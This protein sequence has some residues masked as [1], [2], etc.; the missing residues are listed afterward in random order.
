MRRAAFSSSSA[1]R[2]C[3]TTRSPG[4]PSRHPRHSFPRSR[5][6]T[7]TGTPVLDE[8]LADLLR[9]RH[10]A[11]LA[12]RA[13]D[14]DR[15][16]ALPLGRV[17]R[18]E[19]VEEVLEAREELARLGPRVEEGPDLARAGR[20]AAAARRRSTGSGGTGRRR[21]GPPRPGT[22]YLNPNDTTWTFKAVVGVVLAE[23]GLEERA[24]LVR[25]EAAGVDDPVGDVAQ[26]RQDR[27]ARPGSPSR[28]SRPASCIG[29]G[30]RRLAE[31]ALQDLVG[32]LEEQQRDRRA[33]RLAALS[34]DL[35][36]PAEELPL[37]RVD[38]D[39]PARDRARRSA[40]AARR[41][42]GSG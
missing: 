7:E 37:A 9:Q 30:R 10:R 33:V 17:V 40:G 16:V 11:V 35:G 19:E 29:C 38:D 4:A 28:A 39:R 22:P 1:S 41:T 24:Q 27:R 2:P 13:A 8:V 36:K 5:C 25:V 6:V 23:R 21:G 34:S 32:A 42:A 20:P 14:R 26:R 18:D 15:Q 3:V 31:A 12:A